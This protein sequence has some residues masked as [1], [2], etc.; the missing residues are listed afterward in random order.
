MAWLYCFCDCLCIGADSGDMLYIEECDHKK[1][2]R[3]IHIL[4][5]LDTIYYA[6]VYLLF[7]TA[8]DYSGNEKCSRCDGSCYNNRHE[9]CS[10]YCRGNTRWTAGC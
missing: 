1:N 4:F 6:A 5:P 2:C 9:F 7:W 3:I 8:A 10:F